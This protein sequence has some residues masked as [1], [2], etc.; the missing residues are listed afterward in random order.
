VNPPPAVVSS[1]A[2]AD[3]IDAVRAF[4]SERLKRSF[5]AD[6]A[7]FGPLEFLEHRAAP[8]LVAVGDGW[9]KGALDVRHEHFA[10][11][12]LGD[13]LRA[14]RSP[15]DDRTA[16][17][18]VALATLSGELHG[19]GLQMAALV[20]ALAGWRVLVLGVDTP[21]A[22]IVAL[23]REASIAAVAL[24]CVQ[25]RSRSTDAAVRGL[26]E[27][28][29]RRIPLIVGGAG[30]PPVARGSG[31]EIMSDLASLERW[32]HQRPAA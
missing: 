6:W 28:L 26:R 32:L 31:M 30:A 9:A 15:L 18:I 5:Q 22:Q 11:A 12:C 8:F 21:S 24:S 16:G 7:R 2:P 14:V 17:P 4:D 25:P 3:L 27:R 19:L 23:A 29:P 1:A 13:F 10:S 20:F